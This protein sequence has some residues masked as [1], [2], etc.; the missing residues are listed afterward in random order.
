MIG[1]H[2]H[3]QTADERILPGGTACLTD[4]GM[5]GPHDGV[6]GMD[7]DAVIARFVTGIAGAIRDGHRR[8][9]PAR[10]RRSRSIRRPGAPR[11]RS[12]SRCPK[13]SSSRSLTASRRRRAHESP[14]VSTTNPRLRTVPEVP[15]G[16]KGIVRKRFQVPVPTENRGTA[17]ERRLGTAWNPWN[18]PAPS[19]RTVL[20]VSELNAT[21]RDLLE[22]AVAEGVGRG[23]ALERPGL[24]HRATCTSR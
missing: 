15:T 6:I 17:P 3:V 14:S 21:I 19:A 16:S 24:E 9:A 23:R 18:R 5:T 10:R 1:T 12:A 20:T 11:H 22:N 7:K 2:T 13:T 4:V 8:S